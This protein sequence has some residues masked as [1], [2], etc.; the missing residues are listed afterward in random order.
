MIV[1][2]ASAIVAFLLRE[3]HHEIV[4]S[5]LLREDIHSVDFMLAECASAI[6]RAARRSRITEEE[7]RTILEVLEELQPI[8]TH[9]SSRRLVLKAFQ[10]ARKLGGSVYDWL[11]LRLAEE[12]DA[13]FL[14][15]DKKINA[16]ARK[17]GV[18]TV[19]NDESL[20]G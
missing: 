20:A 14:S 10:G 3:P 8:I 13:A 15:M 1:I 19:I 16:D 18:E 17:L 5:C 12:L 9:H 2:D 11:Y 6:L 7:T 4:E